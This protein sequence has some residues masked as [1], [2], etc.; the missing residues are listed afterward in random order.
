[1]VETL[2]K[3]VKK[4][5]SHF[6]EISGLDACVLNL[7]DQRFYEEPPAFCRDY[8]PCMTAGCDCFR[9]HLRNCLEAERWD[10]RYTYYCPLNLLFVAA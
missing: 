6:E 10:G 1:M 2:H 5:A 3:R 4:Y 9:V 7:V 8:C